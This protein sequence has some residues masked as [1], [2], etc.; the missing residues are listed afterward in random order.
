MLN[1]PA[2]LIA[3]S[4]LVILFL[5]TVHLVFTFRGPAFHPRDPALK[6][7]MQ[8]DSPRISRAT[9]MW[10]AGIGFHASHS[11]GAMMFGV[12]YV[13]LAL[14]GTGFLFHTRFLLALG[15]VV[16]LSYL[17]LAKMFWFK[18]PFRGIGLAT[19]L[20]GAGLAVHLAR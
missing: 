12:I 11:L 13:Y 10:R 15:M 9:T 8:A 6:A 2:M 1:L 16:L 4:A 18:V 20:F 5:G 7:A 19:L 3:A 14:E 17:V